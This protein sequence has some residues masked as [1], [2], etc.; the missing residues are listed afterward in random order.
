MQEESSQSDVAEVPA[1]LDTVV[2]LLVGRREGRSWAPAK[3]KKQRSLAAEVS[4]RFLAPPGRRGISRR[5]E[6][7][8]EGYAAAD[9]DCHHGPKIKIV[10][11]YS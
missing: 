4:R 2:G 1:K 3:K 10:S 8:G 9:H 6:K 11:L 7:N 5:T